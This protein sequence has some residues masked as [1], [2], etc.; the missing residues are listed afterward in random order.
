MVVEILQL[1]RDPFRYYLTAPQKT[2]TSCA[3]STCS[4][5]YMGVTTGLRTSRPIN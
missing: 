5:P 4:H 1:S 3:A 2:S